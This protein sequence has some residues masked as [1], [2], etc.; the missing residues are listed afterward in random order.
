MSK[1]M[2]DGKPST[3]FSRQDREWVKSMRGGG[4]PEITESD[5]GKV[6]TVESGEA[7]W[8]KGGIL[9]IHSSVIPD[10]PNENEILDKTWQEIYDAVSSGI[11]AFILC[12]VA[13]EGMEEQ[14]YLQMPVIYVQNTENSPYT[15]NA[16]T[17]SEDFTA[18]ASSASG[19]P[20][21]HYE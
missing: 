17:G 21:T 3:V 7:A 5:E 10:D 18:S 4:L 6:L 16:L 14:V 19:Y 11:P 1:I 9:V 8:A 2:K 15:I 12:D 20:Q 13:S